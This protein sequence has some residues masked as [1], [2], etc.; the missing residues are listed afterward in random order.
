MPTALPQPT[1]ARAQYQLALELNPR[2]SIEELTVDTSADLNRAAQA[3]DGPKPAIGIVRPLREP[4]GP[5][6]ALD[7]AWLQLKSTRGRCSILGEL[8]EVVGED[9]TLKLIRAFGGTRLYVPHSPEPNDPLSCAIG[10]FAALKLA[11]IY[12][13]DRVDVPNPPPRR[14]RIM[15]LRAS[16][17]SV[18]AIA[19]ELQCTRRRVFQ[20][21]AEAR[22]SGRAE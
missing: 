21:L 20:V 16:G 9:A 12:G 6:Q 5:Q 17:M 22:G 4:P 11:R 7:P 8:I 18:D 13:G 14:V 1:P 2:P 10:H 19:R 3:C 15:Q